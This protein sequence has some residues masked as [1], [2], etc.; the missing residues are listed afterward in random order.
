MLNSSKA[1]IGLSTSAHVAAQLVGYMKLHPENADE[2]WL[3]FMSGMAGAM[4]AHIGFESADA[5][6][7]SV[8]EIHAKAKA[9]INQQ[10]H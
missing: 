7:A 9:K 5:I 8:V 10:T 3:S 2:F 1:V 4:A 6:L